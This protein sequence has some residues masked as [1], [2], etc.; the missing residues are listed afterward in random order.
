MR[1]EKEEGPGGWQGSTVQVK[2][3]FMN[4]QM[5][6][7]LLINLLILSSFFS[8]LDHAVHAPLCH[9]QQPHS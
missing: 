3:A 9:C 6:C 7:Q 5:V 4:G 8:Q 2:I 1:I